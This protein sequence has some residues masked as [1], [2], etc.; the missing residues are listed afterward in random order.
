MGLFFLG[1]PSFHKGEFIWE[2]FLHHSISSSKNIQ[3]SQ[4]FMVP[5][6][7]DACR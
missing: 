3:H 1:V 6:V 4:L 5:N 2:S 7:K